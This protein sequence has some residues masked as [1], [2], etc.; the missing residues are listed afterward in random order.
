VTVSTLPTPTSTRSIRRFRVAV[1]A[2]SKPHR[3][4]EAPA[5]RCVVGSHP[6]CDLI[7][8]D[9]T[10]SRFHCEL[11]IAGDRIRVTDL[12][13]RNGTL[14]NNVIVEKGLV[15][16]GAL[17]GLGGSQLRIDVDDALHLVDIPGSARRSFGSHVGGSA[18][19]RELFLLLERI[20][21]SDVTVLVEGETGTGKEG[22]A[23]AIHDA[24][25]RANGK[26]VVIDCG[27]IPANLLESELFGHEAGAFTGATSRRIG[28]FE[29]ASGGTLFLDEIGE[30]PLELQ[31]KLL[32][33]LES[34]EIRRVGGHEQIACD[35]R[36]IAATNRDLRA[37][38]NRG[39]FRPD[40]Y[41]R[42]AV[43]RVELPPLRDRRD[44]I[45][46]LVDTLLDRLA[47]PAA[48]RARLTAPSFVAE[49]AAAPWPGNVRELRN[50][51]E[52]CVVFDECRSPIALAPA[53]PSTAIDV[54]LPYEV[55]RRQAIEAFERAFVTALLEHHEGN[56]AR[57]AR[58]AGVNR[59][60]LHQLLRRH[61]L[62]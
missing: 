22:V 34:R 53:H 12:G 55:S 6:S 21:A 62:R 61:G 4:W 7:V 16:D 54:T 2:G 36:I 45:P 59:G 31:P 26:F 52:Q 44:D 41:Y 32:R 33:A 29:E 25:D 3:R 39:T 56:V 5:E 42:L 20:A 28:A 46:L 57:A 60:Y 37:E 13:S 48:I 8:D 10:V 17:L 50:H 9:P 38:V 18:A 27:A 49:L 24:S 30:L 35:L 58:A 51:L 11:T 40:V 43:A 19:M 47:A 23:E 1:I 14:A 15:A